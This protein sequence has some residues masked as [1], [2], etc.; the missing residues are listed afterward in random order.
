MLKSLDGQM[1]DEGDHFEPFFKKDFQ[2]HDCLAVIYYQ[3]EHLY[4]KPT[5]SCFSKGK[6]RC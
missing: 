1:S 3:N 5:F 4:K 2:D 6:G